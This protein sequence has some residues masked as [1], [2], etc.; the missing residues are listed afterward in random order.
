MGLEFEIIEELKN[1]GK[2]DIS[3]NEACNT[4]TGSRT[5]LLN[6]SWTTSKGYKVGLTLNKQQVY[7]M[8]ERFE[9]FLIYSSERVT[10]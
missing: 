4:N 8:S 1:I 5:P 2:F 9:E 7:E 10:T 3:I 6:V